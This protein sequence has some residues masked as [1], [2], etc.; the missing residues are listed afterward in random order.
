MRRKT[1]ELCRQ[2]LFDDVDRMKKNGVPECTRARILRLR[3]AYTYWNEFPTTGDKQ[4]RDFLMEQFG[5]EKT[6]AYEDIKLIKT[7]IGE[8]SETS[9]SFHRWKFN[10]MTQ[11]TYDEAKE[12]GNMIVM[13]MTTANY[14]K[15]NQLDKE[16]ATVI[17]WDDIAIQPF[18]PTSDPSV[19][20]IKP[21]ANIEARIE[22]LKQKY[23]SEDIEDITYEDIDLNNHLREEDENDE[24]IL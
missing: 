20:G 15:Y 4:I 7:L 14:G 16:D 19:L 22:A 3:S 13:A 8:T 11:E 21:V 1:L 23:M 12:V 6:A 5:V 17:A 10:Q 24:S 18:E 9:K 2:H